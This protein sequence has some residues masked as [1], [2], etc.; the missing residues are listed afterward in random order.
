MTI[1][2]VVPG[3]AGLPKVE[4]K[5][6][7]AGWNDSGWRFRLVSADGKRSTRW[8]GYTEFCVLDGW[9]CGT[10]YALDEKSAMT[11]LPLD[12]ILPFIAAT[13]EQPQ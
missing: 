8:A 6:Q 10:E 3:P 4:T 12:E 2:Q 7:S 9:A 5:E 11:P 13:M 1:S